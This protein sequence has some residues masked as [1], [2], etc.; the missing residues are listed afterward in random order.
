MV[1]RSSE[2]RF[3]R[4]RMIVMRLKVKHLIPVMK[5]FVGLG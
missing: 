3:L 5:L 4:L 1:D 2:R